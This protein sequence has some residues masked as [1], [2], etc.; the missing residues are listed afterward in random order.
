MNE[1]MLFT[2][3]TWQRQSHISHGQS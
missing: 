3:Q 2:H 1:I